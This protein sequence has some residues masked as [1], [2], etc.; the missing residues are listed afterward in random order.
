MWYKNMEN[1]HLP[2]ANEPLFPSL[3]HPQQKLTD[4]RSFSRVKQKLFP[5][6]L[7]LIM[8][9]SLSAGALLGVWL[10]PYCPTQTIQNYL[11]VHLPYMAPSLPSVSFPLQFLRLCLSCLP[12]FLL[13]CVAGMTSFCQSI[14]VL[15][16]CYRGVCEG[17]SL[18]LFGQLALE[19]LLTDAQ[20]PQLSWTSVCLLYGGWVAI[21]CGIRFYLCLSSAHT[22]LHFFDPDKR[23]KEGQRGFSPLLM[24]HIR[25]SLI[26]AMLGMMACGGYL[27]LL[28]GI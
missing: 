5:L 12:S 23:L 11:K 19:R 28:G 6:R 8:L 9:L 26:S 20:P 14:S 16:L 25:V 3:P 24:R 13:L 10:L 4:T 18:Y 15:V 27:W 2:P 22:S 21:R 1:T 17:Y 7:V